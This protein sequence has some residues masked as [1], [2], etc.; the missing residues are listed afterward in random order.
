MSLDPGRRMSILDEEVGDALDEPA[1]TADVAD[2][3]EFA[4][5]QD[6]CHHRLIDA[7]RLA[8]PPGRDA[9][10]GGIGEVETRAGSGMLFDS[11]A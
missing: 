11:R 6:G 2:G 8:Q 10:A 4:R 5:P 9:P 3:L 7:S 1:G